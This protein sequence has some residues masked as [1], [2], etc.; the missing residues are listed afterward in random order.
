ML[1]WLW[2]S[3]AVL[4]LD[5]ASKLWVDAAFKLYESVVLLPVFNLTYVRNTGAAFSFLGD[6]GGWQRWL[7]MG[8]A[9]AASGILARWLWQL[10]AGQHWQAAGFSLVLGGAVGNLVDRAAY[11]Y[12]IDFF[13]FHVGDWHFAA[14]NVADSAITVGV[15]LLLIDAFWGSESV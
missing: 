12:V 14:F 3:V 11:G 8:L 5:Q 7:F 1:R 13:D 6:A 15:A 2:L 4:V 10:K 9:V